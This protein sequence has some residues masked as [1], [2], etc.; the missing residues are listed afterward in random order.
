[1]NAVPAKVSASGT[2]RQTHNQE[3]MP[4]LNTHLPQGFGAGVK[5]RRILPL[6]R[7]RPASDTV[8]G[9]TSDM[10]LYEANKIKRFYKSFNRLTAN[11]W[12]NKS[13]YT[14]FINTSRVQIND[15]RKNATQ[16]LG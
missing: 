5:I 11:L 8:Q 16:S 12:C 13:V 6:L 14:A 7:Q 15:L 2:D 10:Y 1:L 9:T 3:T 4:T